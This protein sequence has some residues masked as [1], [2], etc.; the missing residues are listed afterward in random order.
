MSSTPMDSEFSCLLEQ[1]QQYLF[2]DESSIQALSPSNENSSDAMAE[3]ES[4]EPPVWKRRYRGVMRRPWGKF[5]A[6]IRDRRKNSARVWL[7][8]YHTE[9]EAALAYDKAAFKMRGRKA[10]LNFPFLIGSDESMIAPNRSLVELSPLPSSNDSCDSQEPKRR[11]NLVDLLN[12]LAK[13]RSHAKHVVEMA[14]ETTE[15]EQWLNDL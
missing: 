4:H 13:S 7:G 12:N 6:E 15:V 1:I 14:L 9:E 5:A 10:K 11:K 8:T 3:R 2:E